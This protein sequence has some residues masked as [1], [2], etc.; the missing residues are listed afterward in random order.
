MKILTHIIKSC[1]E[2]PYTLKSVFDGRIWY[3]CT[4]QNDMPISDEDDI[5]DG[6]PLSDYNPI[7]IDLT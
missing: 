3:Y 6:C 5:D 7:T 1:S 2:C 4:K